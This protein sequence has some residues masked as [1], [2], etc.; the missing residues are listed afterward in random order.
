MSL[1]PTKEVVSTITQEYFLQLSIDA[2]REAVGL[3]I[4]VTST[5]KCFFE[6]DMTWTH[7]GRSCLRKGH[8]E[9]C[10]VGAYEASNVDST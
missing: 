8:A 7:S 2:C 3:R 6:K 4:T 9:V 10:G 1:F 5:Q